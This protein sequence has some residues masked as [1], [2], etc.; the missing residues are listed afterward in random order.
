VGPDINRDICCKGAEM[1]AFNQISQ[2]AVYRQDEI[3][4]SLTCCGGSYGGGSEVLI[5]ELSKSNR[6]ADGK[7]P[8][9]ELL[10]TGCIQ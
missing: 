8:S 4:V 10:R 6:S 5:I 2:S 3:S 1:T 9:R 7:Q